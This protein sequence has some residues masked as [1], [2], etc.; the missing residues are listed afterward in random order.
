MPKNI[1]VLDLETQTIF[2]DHADRKP[3]S[4]GISVVGAYCYRTGE[5]RVYEEREIPVLAHRLADKPLVVGFNIRRFDM[6]VLAPYL[7]FDPL[8]LP[9]VDMLEQLHT[10]L[11]HRVSLESVAVA[12][13]GHGKSGSG[14][15]AVEY[16][17]KGEMAKLKQYCLDDVRVT[18]EIFEYGAAHGEVFYTAKFG[19][20][21]GRA[22][23]TWQVEHP[24]ETGAQ[25]AQMG[26]F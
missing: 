15:D 7:P 4:L 10:I 22:A 14:L 19:S 23:V 12:T 9:M 6:P 21:K 2:S 5:Y 26:L 11:G 1:L 16:Y 8:Q 24:E 18:R 13:L 20:A 25:A 3:G 17:R